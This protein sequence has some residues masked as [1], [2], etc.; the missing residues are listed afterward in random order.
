MKFVE[1]PSSEALGHILEP[2]FCSL[3]EKFLIEEYFEFK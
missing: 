3:T 1:K 2:N